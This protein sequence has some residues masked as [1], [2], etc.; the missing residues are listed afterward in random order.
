MRLIASFKNKI[1]QKQMGI[2]IGY[3]EANY[4]RHYVEDI[5][6]S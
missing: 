2:Q 6:V 3:V 4:Y 1:L 5:H